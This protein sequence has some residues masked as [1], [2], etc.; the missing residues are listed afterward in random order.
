MKI[1]KLFTAFIVC[2]VSLGTAAAVSAQTEKVEYTD[3]SNQTVTYLKDTDESGNVSLYFENE[4]LTDNYAQASYKMDENTVLFK[5][6]TLRS[7]NN[8]MRAYWE[9]NKKTTGCDYNSDMLPADNTGDLSWKI[10]GTVEQGEYYNSGALTLPSLSGGYIY[11]SKGYSWNNISVTPGSEKAII[12]SN[13]NFGDAY[14]YISCG[15]T[16]TAF[17]GIT[18]DGGLYIMPTGKTTFDNCIFTGQLRVPNGNG[19]LTVNSCHFTGEKGVKDSDGYVMHVQSGGSFEFTGNTIDSGVYKRGLNVDNTALTS[20]ISG[21]TIGSVSD[22]G[23]SAIQISSAA[24]LSIENN[25]FNLS[26]TNNAFTLHS[27]LL[28]CMPKAE[29]TIKGNTINGNGYLLYDDALADG[30]E[31]TADNITIIIDSSNK[32]AD[33]VNTK[34]GIK[35]GTVYNLK[36]DGYI[37]N[38]INAP[39]VKWETMTDSGLYTVDTEKFGVMRFSFKAAVTDEIKSVGIKFINANNIKASLKADDAQLKTDGSIA[40]FYGDL[41]K[42]NSGSTDKYYAAAYIITNGEPIWSDIVEC[43]LDTNKTFTNYGGAQ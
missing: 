17:T 33:T 7:V 21:N 41:T 11:S 19:K 14:S 37:Y 40:S 24:Q 27:K 9:V 23:R 26:D 15:L 22:A 3:K 10:Y 39:A 2:M 4:D 43:T 12:V 28:T 25:T 1:K 13:D 38:A 18:L 6:K 16:S 32:I 5:G 20:T 31:F 42:I 8:L 36:E 35:G 29:I 30:K 34:A